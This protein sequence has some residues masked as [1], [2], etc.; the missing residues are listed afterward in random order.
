M[1][2]CL[3]FHGAQGH[4]LY[5]GPTSECEDYFKTQ[6]GFISVSTNPADF[7][8]HVARETRDNPDSCQFPLEHMA[9]MAKKQFY[10]DSDILRDTGP[11]LLES[12]SKS[13]VTGIHY[14][15]NLMAENINADIEDVKKSRVTIRVLYER[16]FLKELRRWKFWL[17]NIVRA[18]MLGCLLGR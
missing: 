11:T 6:C 8:I 5:F 18:V 10:S 4:V 13:D 17:T 3:C 7:I 14:V 9:A 2:N 15:F 1:F 12:D 16:E